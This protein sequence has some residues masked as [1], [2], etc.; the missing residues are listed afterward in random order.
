MIATATPQD[1]EP[2]AG[3]ATQPDR[4]HQPLQRPRGSSV[5]DPMAAV[6]SGASALTTSMGAAK[7]AHGAAAMLVAQPGGWRDTAQNGGD[8][9][10]DAE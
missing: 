6:T 9:V 10:G 7:R 8:A 4:Q 5:A 2:E 3:D 1:G